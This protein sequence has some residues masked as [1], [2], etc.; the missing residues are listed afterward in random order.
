[1]WRYSTIGDCMSFNMYN[2]T[3]SRTGVTVVLTETELDAIY[4]AMRGGEFAIMGDDEMETVD[5]VVDKLFTL[6][7]ESK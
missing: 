4:I 5:S 7:K 3:N 6:C 2:L 1:M